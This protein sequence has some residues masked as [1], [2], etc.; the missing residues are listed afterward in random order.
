MSD[1]SGFS[2]SST[3]SRLSECDSMEG[4]RVLKNDSYKV[5]THIMKDCTYYIDNN[6]ICRCIMHKPYVH[7]EFIE[8]LYI[9]SFPVAKLTIIYKIQNN[10]LWTLGNFPSASWKFWSTEAGKERRWEQPRKRWCAQGSVGVSG[11]I[12][13]VSLWHMHNAGK[14]KLQHE[15]LWSATMLFQRHVFVSAYVKDVQLCRYCVYSWDFLVYEFEYHKICTFVLLCPYQ[16]VYKCVFVC[17]SDVCRLSVCGFCLCGHAY[18]VHIWKWGFAHI[19][20]GLDVHIHSHPWHKG[21]CFPPT[22]H[23]V[24]LWCHC[25]LLCVFDSDFGAQ[26]CEASITA[27]IT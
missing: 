17:D 16:D 25:V 13:G 4:I 2:G 22:T 11:R 21:L 6:T 9:H 3:N 23:A 27:I 10:C 7:L 19:H 5:A 14:S 1:V 8:I 24:S 18:D 20:V 12:Y 15:G 26:S